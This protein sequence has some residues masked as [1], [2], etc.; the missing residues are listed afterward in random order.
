M[1]LGSQHFE[2]QRGVQELWD[3][4]RK[5]DKHQLLTQTRTKPTQGG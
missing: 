5:S 3:G 1:L 2:G 4:I